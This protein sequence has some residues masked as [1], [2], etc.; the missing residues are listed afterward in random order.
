MKCPECGVEQKKDVERRCRC[1]YQFIFHARNAQGMTDAKFFNLLRRAGGNGQFYFSFPQLYSAWCQQDAEERIYLLRKKLAGV[2]VFLLT[3]CIFFF[4]LFGWIGGVLSLIL[5][6]G[7]WLLIRQYRRQL[8]P[9]LGTLKILLKQWQ[10]GHGGGDEMLLIRPSLHEPPLD[11][12]EKDLFDYGVERIIIVERPLLVDL[13]VKN[14]FHADQNALIF[15]RDGYPAYI[16]QRAQE[17]LKE[18]SLLPI[19]LLHDASETG[20]AMSEKNKLSGRTV[21]DLGIRPEHLEKM[22]FL[23]ALQL[24]RNGYKAPLDIL[25]YPVLATICGEAVR[26]NS[27][28]LEVLEQ[29]DTQR[30]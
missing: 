6:V 22:H 3:L 14:G 13:L 27:T 2:G 19:Y 18:R 30:V 16:V 23:Y 29:W 21:I 4:L 25:P 11:F 5:L 17:I 26:K 1:G 7:P 9:D 10:A 12:S 15:S 24:Q 8:P 28:L 20:M